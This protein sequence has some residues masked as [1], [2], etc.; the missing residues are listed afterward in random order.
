MEIQELR[1]SMGLTQKQFA[2]YFG[3]N[4]RTLQDWECGRSRTPTYL[5]NLLLR[6]NKAEGYEKVK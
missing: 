4:V 5:V 6:L 2:T 3:L 1:K